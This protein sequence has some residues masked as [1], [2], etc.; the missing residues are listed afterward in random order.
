MDTTYAAVVQSSNAIVATG[1]LA[2]GNQL[3]GYQ[4]QEDQLNAEQLLLASLDILDS[5]ACAEA[6]QTMVQAMVDGVNIGDRELRGRRQRHQ[7]HGDGQR[8]ELPDDAVAEFRRRRAH[9]GARLRE[10]RRFRR[11]GDLRRPGADRPPENAY[12]AAQVPLAGEFPQFYIENPLGVAGQS[13]DTTIRQVADNGY[14]AV[15]VKLCTAGGAYYSTNVT[16]PILDANGNPTGNYASYP[17]MYLPQNGGNG[18]NQLDPNNPAAPVRVQQ[19]WSEALCLDGVYELRVG[20]DRLDQR[21]RGLDDDSV[22]LESAS[23]RSL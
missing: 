10:Q 1:C 15:V 6:G 22:R 7:Q 19:V 11:R 9:V 18:V 23:R 5:A 12:S 8:R 2:V 3:Y 14:N 20:D 13:W 4:S 21:D 16:T 17:E